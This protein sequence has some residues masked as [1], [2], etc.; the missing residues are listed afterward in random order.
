MKRPDAFEVFLASFCVATIVV[1]CIGTAR[2][3]GEWRRSR[4]ASA[5]DAGADAWGGDLTSALPC[6][7]GGCLL[8][9]SDRPVCDEDAGCI[10]FREIDEFDAASFGSGA[11]VFFTGGAEQLRLEPDGTIW[12]HGHRAATDREVVEGMRRIVRG[13]CPAK[14]GGAR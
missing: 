4:D 13:E 1:V 5:L 10:T 11:I 9:A 12:I 2:T 6:P 7:D 3:I 8:T 14:D